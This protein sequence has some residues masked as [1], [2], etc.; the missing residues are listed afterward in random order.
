MSVEDDLL[1]LDSWPVLEWLRQREPSV[2]RFDFLPDS[3]RRGDVLLIMSSVNLGEILYNAWSLWGELRAEEVIADFDALPI[4]VFHPKQEDA[5]AA[6]CIKGRYKCSYADGFAVILA[7]EFR[8]TV[9]TGDPDFLKMRDGGAEK[10]DW[11]GA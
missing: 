2:S 1:V 5:M 8:A 10:V 9:V 4:H 3:A 6:A 11:W 7:A